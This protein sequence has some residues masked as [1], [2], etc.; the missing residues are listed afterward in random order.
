[1]YKELYKTLIDRAREENRAKHQGTYYEQHHIIPDFLF[2]NRTRSGPKGHL[3]GDPNGFENLI[4]LTF[5]EHLMAHYYLYEIYKDTRY[6]YSAGTA[7]QFFF[8][9]AAGNHK[10]QLNLSEVDE[11]FLAE[12]SHLRSLGIESISKARSGKMPA[13][14]AITREKKGS[15]S[16][17]HPKV[18]SGEWVHHSKGR[19][20]VT[21]PEKRKSQKGANNNNYKELTPERKERLIKC[22]TESCQD[23]YLKQ[24]LLN[25]NIKKE[26]NEFKKISLKWVYNNY[27]SIINLLYETN[28]KLN[29]NI[30]FDPYHRSQRQR[31]IAAAHSSTHRWYNNGV[32]N[33]RVIDEH[34][35]C[36]NNPN[37][38][39]GKIKT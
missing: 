36:K 16:I 30:K 25:K 37:Y 19:P 15:V 38:V 28:T 21:K 9:K 1:M 7:L 32:T 4:L 17:H 8:V 22:V 29:L 31:E 35:F 26:F 5:S 39:P 34:E 6:G 3:D 11:Q 18:L 33:T 14:D 13:V 23:G 27:G 12:M 20:S 10:R 2:K 24:N